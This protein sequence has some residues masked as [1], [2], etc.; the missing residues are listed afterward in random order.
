MIFFSPKPLRFKGFQVASTV[1]AS[2]SAAIAVA[3]SDA[4]A[5]ALR[6]E[7]DTVFSHYCRENFIRPDYHTPYS[8]E[9]VFH[10]FAWLPGESFAFARLTNADFR[11][12]VLMG[13]NFYGAAA[14]NADFRGARLDG[15][16][17]RRADFTSADFSCAD[18]DGAQLNGANLT[19]AKFTDATVIAAQF[20]NV[21]ANGPISLRFSKDAA[22]PQPSAEACAFWAGAETGAQR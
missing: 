7:A 1:V 3:S 19:D 14:P 10:N 8:D 15:S 12:A 20:A 5:D 16:D 13:A 9:G 2:L 4:E 6:S 11:C 18:L 22:P 21:C 17:L